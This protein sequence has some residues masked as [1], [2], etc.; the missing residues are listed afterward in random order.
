MSIVYYV[1]KELIVGNKKTI[2][3]EAVENIELDIADGSEASPSY[4]F[5]NDPTSGMY[6]STS[7]E[8]AIS[9]GGVALLKLS[10]RGNKDISLTT[11]Q[12][13][14]LTG[15]TGGEW[16]FN[17]STERPMWYDAGISQWIAV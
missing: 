9:G 1:K 4:S 11:S 10:Q 14:A 3:F 8:P 6:C 2:S 15:M 17:E 12:I 16:V 13:N 5:Q 7:S